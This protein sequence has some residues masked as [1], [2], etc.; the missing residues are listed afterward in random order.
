MKFKDG[1]IVTYRGYELVLRI[2][3]NQYTGEEIYY[4][5][6]TDGK[7]FTSNF[8]FDELN[9]YSVE[10]SN[11][12][13]AGNS[14]GSVQNSG[15]GYSS[16]NSSSSSGGSNKQNSRTNNLENAKKLSDDIGSLYETSK[17]LAECTSLVNDAKN[18]IKTNNI[19]LNTWNDVKNAKGFATEA[20]IAFLS[21]L[22]EAFDVVY[23]N[24]EAT[25]SAA[26]ELDDLNKN[27]K[28]LIIKFAEKLE[29]EKEKKAKETELSNTPKEIEDGT[30]SEGNITYKA[31]PR[32]AELENEISELSTKISKLESDIATL[33][34][35]I[36]AKYKNM[37][38]KYS[39]LRELGTKYNG[40]NFEIDDTIFGTNGTVDE[41]YSILIKDV[42][43]KLVSIDYGGRNFYM[44]NSSI[45]PVDYYQYIK[46]NDLY[47]N[48][49]F[50]G[51]QCMIL[52]LV[53]TKDMTTGSY[54][55]PDGFWSSGVNATMDSVVSHDANKI[56]DY[57]YNEI[58]NGNPVTLQVTQKAG[59]RHFVT[60]VGFDSSVKS[61]SDLTPDNLLV[62]D[63]VDGDIQLL[64]DR[65]RTLK[66][67][68]GG[69]QACSFRHLVDA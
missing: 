66:D 37:K 12:G 40:I 5:C 57:T 31:N 19:T 27:L 21:G 25:S 34:S 49:G 24:L 22:S 67:N 64:S 8:S 53:Y 38:S 6:T 62:L 17:E 3:K 20:S 35:I 59:G 23:N 1:D 58:T 55:S 60:V 46:D 39:E 30:D 7:I 2:I 68:G 61:A 9:S 69:Y 11:A 50:L 41:K 36:D 29:L 4:L 48:K 13:S 10:A 45:S 63:C 32:I 51:G 42:G 44:L 43:D 33:Q 14:N 26:K 47:Q 52:S 28:I 65:D 54:T 16:G 18:A 56:L 15:S